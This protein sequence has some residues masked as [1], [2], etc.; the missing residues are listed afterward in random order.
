MDIHSNIRK[1]LLFLL[2]IALV[3]LIYNEAAN[4]HYHISSSG[5][6]VKH[7]HPFNKTE[8][9]ASPFAN[10]SHTAL[11][12][13]FYGQFSFV[14]FTLVLALSLGLLLRLTKQTRLSHYSFPFLEQIAG[15]LPPLRAPPR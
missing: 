12:M 8:N 9:P 6:P 13:L 11:E 3:S 4:W 1:L 10:H 7:A 2:L 5:I 15:S 14:V